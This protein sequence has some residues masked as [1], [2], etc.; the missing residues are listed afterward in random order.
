MRILIVE[1]D[2]DQRD[3][4]KETLEDHFGHGTVTGAACGHEALGLDLQTFDVILTDFNLPDVVGMDF[5]RAALTRCDRPII[6]VTGENVRQTAAQA[7]RA[8]AYDYLVKSGEYLFTI[9]LVIEKNIEAWKV[10]Q[11]NKRLHEQQQAAA[12]EISLKNQQ[13]K[14]SLQKLEQMAA[15]DPLTGLYNRRHFGEVLERYFAESARYG[16]DLACIMCD[17]DGYKKLNDTL[18]HQF[19]DKIL[20]V[21][22]AIVSRNLRVMDIAARYGGDEFVILLPHAGSGEALRVGERIREQFVSQIRAMLPATPEGLTLTMSMGLSS[23]Q[24]NRPANSDQLVA[25]A[26]EALYDAKH[27]GKNRA[28]NSERVRPAAPAAETVS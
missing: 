1:D 13:L 25:L 12:R 17:L 18:G 24:R 21:T 10:K 7:I 26:D 2:M 5:L 28:V 6:V 22:A 27:R 19:G 20:Q 8:G 14:E 9:P 4:M 3:L 11:E 16:Q 23:V 15:T